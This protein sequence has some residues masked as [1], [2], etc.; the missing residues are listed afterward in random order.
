MVNHQ[1][2]KQMLKDFP[3]IT[4]TTEYTDKPKHAHR[5]D[6]ELINEYPNRQNPCFF[7]RN[8]AVIEANFNDLT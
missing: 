7:L 5:L 4:G 1:E 3:N 6:T 2:A 8:Q